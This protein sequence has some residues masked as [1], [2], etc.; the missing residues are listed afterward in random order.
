MTCSST[1]HALP[2]I[3]T[4]GVKLAAA[5]FAGGVTAKRTIVSSPAFASSIGIA[6]GSTRHPAGTGRVTRPLTPSRPARTR[7]TTGAG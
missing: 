3:S 4:E 6:A 7:S 1:L 5:A 2:S